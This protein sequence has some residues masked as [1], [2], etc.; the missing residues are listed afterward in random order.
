MAKPKITSPSRP[1]QYDPKAPSKDTPRP[2][3]AITSPKIETLP[4]PKKK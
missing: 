1:G 2:L 4:L 3:P